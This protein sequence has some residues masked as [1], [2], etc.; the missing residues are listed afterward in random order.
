MQ[1]LSGCFVIGGKYFVSLLSTLSGSA[2]NKLT[3]GSKESAYSR[4]FARS[5]GVISFAPVEYDTDAV[6]GVSV[7]LAFSAEIGMADSVNAA[8]RISAKNFL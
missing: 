8:D 7:P 3:S 5:S 2:A 1:E 6:S 4:I